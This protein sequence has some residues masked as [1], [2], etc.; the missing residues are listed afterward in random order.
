M[1]K[2]LSCFII[3]PI[4]YIFGPYIH[5]ANK[6]SFN[7]MNK[8]DVSSIEKQRQ[9][10]FDL[11]PN[12]ILDSPCILGEGIIGQNEIE[13][14]NSLKSYAK[15]I[16]HR[17][18]FIPASGSGSRMFQFLYSFLETGVIT[19]EINR[20][21]DELHKLACYKSFS[22]E[23][24]Q[25]IKEKDFIKSAKLILFK[26]GMNYGLIP[27]GL[28]PFHLINGQSRNPF[29]QHVIQAES[30]FDKNYDVQF[31]IQKEFESEIVSSIS[32]VYDK[33]CKK[34]TICYSEQDTNT[35]AFVFSA[36]KSLVY[37]GGMML[38]RPAGHGALL[39]N[40]EESQAEVICIK[41]IDNVQPANESELSTKYWHVA[42]GYIDL[43]KKAAIEL[44]NNFNIE[45]LI[46]FNDRFKVFHNET[47][48]AIT[49]I[50]FECYMKRP[51]R[52]C[53][54]VKNEGKPGGGPFWVNTDGVVS[55]QIVESSQISKEA[56]QQSVLMASTHFNPVF[57]VISKQDVFGN[58]L[59]LF[60]FVD[61]S[62]Y[63][64]VKKSH[65]GKDVFFRELPGLW[66]GSMHNWNSIFIEMP[67]E[68][69][70]PVKSVL[71]LF[72]PP[73]TVD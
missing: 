34:F 26:E 3:P 38:R 5:I 44:L 56:Q 42:I 67:V 33:N 25:S 46:S 63:L 61:D 69:F 39:T 59:C 13:L 6:Q 14:D 8:D 4:F 19:D 57:M 27:K 66:N 41:N 43:F 16:S 65:K 17:E 29:Q 10:V 7:E 15:S 1:P 35:N 21:F 55:K 49:K 37:D 73:H 20:F 2:T 50:D 60:D 11:T 31:T 64:N 32:E 51:I 40:L 48:N 47:L 68:I 28:I 22:E 24:V 70:T 12:L 53:G 36:D 52:V 62:K 45:S 58:K 18:L 72:D 30:I 9:Q 54:M 71:D 23:L